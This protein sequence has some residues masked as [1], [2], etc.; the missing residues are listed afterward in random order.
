M[1]I[2]VFKLYDRTYHSEESYGNF[3]ILTGFLTDDVNWYSL[4]LFKEFINNPHEIQTGGNYSIMEK[5]GDDILIGC[6]FDDMLF[7]PCI[8]MP[9][10]ELLSILH[11]WEEL[12]K[13]RP[14]EIII[15]KRGESYILEG[16]DAPSKE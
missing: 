4:P 16:R 8:K 6:V 5:E 9:Q 10:K 12:V 3:W 2:A 14:A 15:H 7:D 11:Q 1:K 13:L